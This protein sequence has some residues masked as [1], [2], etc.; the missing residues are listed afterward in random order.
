MQKRFY[1]F[2]A[3]AAALFLLSAVVCVGTQE[4]LPAGQRAQPENVRIAPA[5]RQDGQP[6]NIRSD[7]I[8]YSYEFNQPDFLISHTRIEHDATGR[9]RISF[10]RRSETE[11][12]TESLEISPVALNRI[13]NLWSALGSLESGASLQSERQ[14]PHLGT[15]RLGVRRAGGDERTTEF[16]WTSDRNAFALVNEYRRLADQALFVFDIN[17]AREN[18][19]LET[20]AL[21]T[22]LETLVR[23]NAL[24]DARQLVPLLRDLSTDERIP[25]IARNKAERLVQRIDDRN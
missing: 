7:A 4:N 10:R 2:R 5:T 3:F 16:N 13:A 24:S 23:R 22:R 25:L 14:F 8:N 12:L 9:G 6:T 21:M 1:P 15:M 20:P 17:L 19:P 18:Q 11:T